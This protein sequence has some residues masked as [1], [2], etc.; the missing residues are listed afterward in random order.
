MRPP[1]F[2][3]PILLVDDDAMVRSILLEY[4]K[5]F[6]FTHI[7]DVKDSKRA[8]QIIRDPKVPIRLV[9][10]DWEMPDVNGLTLL[11]AMKNCGFRKQTQ[12]I[13]VTSQRSME[14]FKITQAAQ[15]KVSSYLVKPFQAK[16]LKERIWSVLKWHL[17]EKENG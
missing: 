6:G 8:L 5:S 13:M 7:I 11:K 17:D 16:A 15:M 10:S 9:L 2:D 12:F 3:I 14:R 1:D 4:L